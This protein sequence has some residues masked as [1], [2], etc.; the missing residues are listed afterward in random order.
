MTPPRRAPAGAARLLAAAVLLVVDVAEAYLEDASEARELAAE[1]MA[2]LAELSSDDALE[3]RELSSE[4]RLVATLPVAVE[5]SDAA[6]LA[7]EAPSPKME[8]TSEARLVA[9]EAPA[10]RAELMTDAAV[11]VVESAVTRAAR[12]ATRTSSGRI[13][14]WYKLD[15]IEL[16]SGFEVSTDDKVFVYMCKM[17]GQSRS[18]FR[19]G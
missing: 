8:V 7:E 1:V 2:E 10:E 12:P 6:E 17:V 15:E 5:S 19:R 3:E 14:R 13:L 18:L 9:T 11:F 4:L 16:E